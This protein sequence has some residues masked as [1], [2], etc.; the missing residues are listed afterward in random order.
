MLK[1]SDTLDPLLNR[2]FSIAFI[3]REDK[4]L[5]IIYRVVGKGTELLSK[6]R[7][8]EFLW[9]LGPLGHGFANSTDAK[10]PVHPILVAGGMGI[11]PILSIFAMPE[12]HAGPLFWGAR[13][14]MEIFD[15]NVA[16][17]GHVPSPLIITTEDGAR[18]EKGIVT[19][20]LASRLRNMPG[21][22]Y[23][24]T[25][26]ACGPLKMLRVIHGLCSKLGFSLFVS[27]EASMACGMGFCQ[28]CALPRAG[29]GYLKACKDGPVFD[30]SHID[31][32]RIDG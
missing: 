24:K 12:T 10:S 27:L 14:G 29:G 28:G 13:T 7:P 5:D 20:A 16:Y 8:G 4:W 17:P 11:A 2:P 19:D 25:V 32:E 31:W 1:V 22:P 21:L 18:G 6:R 3:N 23:K 15:L 30:S 9:I 26:F